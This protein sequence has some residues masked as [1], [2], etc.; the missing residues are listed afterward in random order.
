MSI[1]FSKMSSAESS[2]SNTTE[3]PYTED[4][5]IIKQI[6]DDALAYFNEC[7]KCKSQFIDN[8]LLA[9]DN[10]CNFD[11]QIK[12][13]EL[14][15]KYKSY[16]NKYKN[17]KIKDNEIIIHDSGKTV[18]SFYGL[19]SFIRLNIN[20]SNHHYSVYYYYHGTEFNINGPS[21][22]IE[23]VEKNRINGSHDHIAKYIR[24][25]FT[26]LNETNDSLNKRIKELES[27]SSNDTII[28]ELK[29]QLNDKDKQIKELK[30]QLSDKDKQIEELNLQLSKKETINNELMYKVIKVDTK[31]RTY[32][33]YMN[34]FTNKIEYISYEDDEGVTHKE[35][36][37]VCRI[38]ENTYGDYK[39]RKIY[40]NL[41]KEKLNDS[42]SNKSVV[43]PNGDEEYWR[44]GIFYGL[45]ELSK[46]K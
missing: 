13:F 5:E 10:N 42:Y 23:N 44:N 20:K 18:H 46:L 40:I 24:E 39:E 12:L 1:Y 16:L 31:L 35:T 36:L 33:I 4:T 22:I 26:K 3:L 9:Y 2:G 45:K 25:E 19:P 27:S 30:L 38:D 14:Y 21:A 43:H 7:I 17:I 34:N 32:N 41:C 37:F 11:E 6:I 15:T 28:E 8:K 29:L